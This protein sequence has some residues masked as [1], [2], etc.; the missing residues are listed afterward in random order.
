M[1]ELKIQIFIEF[2]IREYKLIWAFILEFILSVLT[3]CSSSRL[4][5]FAQS[6]FKFSSRFCLSLS[7]ASN[8]F[9]SDNSDCNLNFVGI[10]ITT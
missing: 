8:T 6:F 9:L 10:T 3:L 4:K 1:G 2:F 5:S 7:S